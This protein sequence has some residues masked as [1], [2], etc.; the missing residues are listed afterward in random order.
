MF[1]A[2]L[3]KFSFDIGQKLE[4][5]LAWILEF[6]EFMAIDHRIFDA[7]GKIKGRML[8]KDAKPKLII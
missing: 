7:N 1:F 2:V 4:I 8:N 6:L 3:G 5:K